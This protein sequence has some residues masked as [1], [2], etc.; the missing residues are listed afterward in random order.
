MHERDML[1]ARKV[2]PSLKSFQKNKTHTHPNFFCPPGVNFVGECVVE[3]RIRKSKPKALCFFPRQCV[4]HVLRSFACKMLINKQTHSEER[5]AGWRCRFNIV[6][7]VQRA[8]T[9]LP[10][11]CICLCTGFTDAA[12]IC[13]SHR[14]GKQTRKQEDCFLLP[15]PWVQLTPKT[16]EK[17]EQKLHVTQPC[18]V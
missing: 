7:I 15:P 1:S 3:K 5:R 9:A 13:F 2:N 8:H 18:K 14:A 6:T 4:R 12:V 16:H 17:T 10:R 11:R